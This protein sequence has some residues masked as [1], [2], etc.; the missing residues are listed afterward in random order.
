MF[1]SGAGKFCLTHWL[2]QLTHDVKSGV[3]PLYFR[4]DGMKTSNNVRERSL[5]NVKYLKI[6]ET[7][8]DK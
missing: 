3:R 1:F 5:C 8:H 2:R 6:K 7:T 4:S